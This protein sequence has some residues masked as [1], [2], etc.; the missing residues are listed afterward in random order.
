VTELHEGVEWF[1]HSGVVGAEDSKIYFKLLVDSFCFSIG[2][3]VIHR[4]SEHFC[5]SFTIS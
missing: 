5:N 2:L 4:A 3:R 1:P